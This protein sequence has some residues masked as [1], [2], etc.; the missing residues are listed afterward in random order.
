[1][2]YTPSA[3][4]SG[5]TTVT[6][7]SPS[8]E[9]GGSVFERLHSGNFAQVGI[10]FQKTSN[11]RLVNSVVVGLQEAVIVANGNVADSGDS[12][13]SGNQFR[14]GAGGTG[15]VYNSIGGLRI[16]NNK[17][18][19]NGNLAF[20]IQMALASGAFTADLFIT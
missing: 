1:M 14:A 2:N 4:N 20:G 15:I 16:I 18:N 3:A 9:N 10:N 13:I 17:I 7:T 6:V 11:F 12:T 19:A 5:V 8:G